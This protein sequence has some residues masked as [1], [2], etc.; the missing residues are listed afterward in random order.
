ML[1][2]PKTAYTVEKWRK[3]EKNRYILC[4]LAVYKIYFWIFRYILRSFSEHLISS[5][6]FWYIFRAQV[7]YEMH[8][9]KQ[10]YITITVTG[11]IKV[12]SQFVEYFLN[13]FRPNKCIESNSIFLK[14][15]IVHELYHESRRYIYWASFRSWDIPFLC[16]VHIISYLST[17]YT[18]NFWGSLNA[19]KKYSI[20]QWKFIWCMAGAE[21]IPAPYFSL[22]LCENCQQWLPHW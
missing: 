21:E 22:N 17:K 19:P 16:T 5:N 20:Y 13:C 18:E 6:I 1:N 12:Q 10:W 3:K 11:I 15:K 4:F 9:T 14:P 2:I 7:V 8:W